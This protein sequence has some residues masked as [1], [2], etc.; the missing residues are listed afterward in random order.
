M[1]EP[2]ELDVLNHLPSDD[3]QQPPADEPRGQFGRYVVHA[4]LA[5]AGHDLE[6]LLAR[7]DDQAR[8]L[9]RRA[10]EYASAKASEVC[11]RERHVWTVHAVP[12]PHL[13]E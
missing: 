2:T 4:Y 9:L 12:T 5:G 6:T 7:N 13:F 11:V 10:L 3:R 8:Q 1:A